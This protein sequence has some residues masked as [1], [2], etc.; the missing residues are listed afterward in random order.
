MSASMVTPVAGLRAAPP[1]TVTR[2]AAISSEACS[3]ERAAPRRTSSAS[4]RSRRGG[5]GQ[6]WPGSPAGASPAVASSAG[7]VERATQ[8]VVRGLED[9][10]VLVHRQRPRGPRARRRT[11][12][13][14]GW[15][16]PSA[17]SAPGRGL[18]G[19]VSAARPRRR[20]SAGLDARPARPWRSR[21]P[22]PAPGTRSPAV[23]AGSPCASRCAQAAAATTRHQSPGSPS[24]STCSAPP[25]T[26]AVQPPADALVAVHLGGL[27]APRPGPPRSAATYVGRC[28][29]VA[30][31]RSLEPGHPGQHQ[32]AVPAGVDGRP[33]CR[34]RAG[35][36]PPA[37]GRRRPGAGSPRTAAARACPRPPAP[38]RRTPRPAR[39]S[40][41]LPGPDARRPSGSSGRCWTRPTAARRARGS[42]R[43]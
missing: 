41:P 35:R 32:Q 5:T 37:G 29:G 34:C 38:A 13:T 9:R 1:L 33:R 28:R 26:R 18:V 2:P 7:L 10:D 3:R 15:P 40:A 6:P 43:R 11:A 22:R 25:S 23:S 12:S 24:P 4:S 19:P 8:R 14:A 30:A 31:A 39:T 42:P 27:R 17:T 21:Y 20:V 16:V 36:R